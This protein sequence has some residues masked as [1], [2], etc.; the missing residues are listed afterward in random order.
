MEVTYKDKALRDIEFWK[1]SGNKQ[2]Q[3]KITALIEDICKHPEVGLGKPEELKY[4]LKGLWSRRINNEH[5][6]IYEFT[7]KQVSIISLK[8]HY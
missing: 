5:R 4:E 7:E 1:K 2:V 6:L 8:G 3:R